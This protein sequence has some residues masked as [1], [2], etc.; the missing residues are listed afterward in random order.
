[1]RTELYKAA[2][3]E[4]SVYLLSGLCD[5]V[6][7]FLEAVGAIVQVEQGLVLTLLPLE[8]RIAAPRGHDLLD[9]LHIVLSVLH[10]LL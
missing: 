4:E 7:P 9:L 5:L 10:S 3:L 6:V 2:Y 8:Q 1:M